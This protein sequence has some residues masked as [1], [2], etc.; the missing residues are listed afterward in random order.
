MMMIPPPPTSR[1]SELTRKCKPQ[2]SLG[3]IAARIAKS[4]RI[5][6][7]EGRKSN[8]SRDL[9]CLLAQTEAKARRNLVKSALL[10]ATCGSTID[11]N[12]MTTLA[13]FSQPTKRLEERDDETSR[14]S[15][16]DASPTS[17]RKSSKAASPRTHATNNM[18]APNGSPRT[19]GKSSSS[20]ESKKKRILSPDYCATPVLF[21]QPSP[22][23][24]EDQGDERTH[25]AP[26][27]LLKSSK[28]E[29]MPEPCP[30]LSPTK[31]P[32]RRS[33][34]KKDGTRRRSTSTRRPDRL[35]ASKT[36]ARSK[37]SHKTPRSPRGRSELSPK[38]RAK[39]N[40]TAKEDSHSQKPGGNEMA[41]ERNHAFDKGI[42]K[43]LRMVGD[44]APISKIKDENSSVYSAIPKMERIR[45]VAKKQRIK[46]LTQ[47]RD[48][49]LMDLESDVNMSEGSKP[50]GK[51]AASSPLGCRPVVSLRDTHFSTKLRK[52]D[53]IF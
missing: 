26:L 20:S 5:I 10:S 51:T 52:L 1:T 39:T 35:D 14:K 3:E 18:R 36:S 8:I 16:I 25:P 28:H 12:Q 13:T 40:N 21:S 45:M 17:R 47:R 43:K 31:A 50:G 24:L 7:L 37:D 9:P 23:R 44:N 27:L 19:Q 46:R 11:E 34:I 33:S 49:D 41:Q 22:K 4:P 42:E 48:L 6:T 38:T 15:I 32:G 2:T 29:P 30:Q 53:L